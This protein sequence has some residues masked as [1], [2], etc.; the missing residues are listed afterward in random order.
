MI[1]KTNSALLIIDMQTKLIPAMHNNQLLLEN[2][3]KLLQAINI[4]QVPVISTVQY[5]KGLGDTLPQL[6][7][8]LPNDEFQDIE[9]FEFSCVK[10]ST[11]FEK[12][13]LLDRQKIFVIGAEAHVCVQQTVLDLMDEDYHPIVIADCIS[14]RNQYDK[15]VAIERMS[16][17]GADITT[18]EAAVFDLL[19]TSKADEFKA[20]SNIVK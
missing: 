6:K 3:A 12:L 16:N 10:N 18:Y 13:Q 9:K 5:K 15:T 7:S 2:S 14:S 8:L 17:Y 1:N 4:L 11:F 20:V 19:K